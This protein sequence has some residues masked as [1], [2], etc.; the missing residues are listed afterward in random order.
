VILW[1]VDEDLVY[2]GDNSL[3]P[4]ATFFGIH[5]IP[6]IVKS[7][8]G[9]GW[10]CPAQLHDFTECNEGSFW[11]IGCSYQ[12]GKDAA[13]IGQVRPGPEGLW[14]ETLLGSERPLL[15]LEGE[16]LPRIC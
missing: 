6:S 1:V 4:A 2:G 16:Q 15:T 10:V 3:V 12:S 5:F 7:A 8:N 11:G 14:L 13:L 9:S